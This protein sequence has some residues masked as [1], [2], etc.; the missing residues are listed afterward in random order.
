[1]QAVRVKGTY[2]VVVVG[3]GASGVGIGIAL[4][5]LGIK[6]TI[7]E[8]HDVGASFAR[9][10]QEM[11]FITPSFPSNE[12]GMPDLNAVTRN[13]S[14]AVTL[15][16]EHPTGR[17]YALYLKRVSAHYRL[18]V[19]GGVEVKSVR[20]EGVGFVT[21]MQKGEVRSRFVVWAAGEFQYPRMAGF[22]GAELC[23]HNGSVR[24]WAELEGDEFIVIGGYESGMD[25]AYH[26]CE[27]GRRVKVFD[28]GNACACTDEDPSVSLSPFTR[29][30][31]A[32][33]QKTG[34]VEMI[35]ERVDSVEKTAGGYVVRAGRRSYT[36]AARP[37]SATGFEGSLKL[38]ADLFYWK[39][40]KAELNVY[41]E[42]TR[43]PGLYVA[44][45]LVER[46]GKIFCFIY[47]F[48]QR[49]PVIAHNIAQK[50]GLDASPLERYLRT[51]ETSEPRSRA[52]RKKDACSC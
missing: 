12:F 11:R 32:R 10:P 1:M 22:P 24:S 3:A 35:K 23:V 51:G 34:R 41:D 40:G 4:K 52:P 31:L 37:I 33:A 26:L 49:F 45:P 44:G 47:K 28:G 19:Q 43:T 27:L 21:S 6:F 48:Q 29:D 39:E 14:P 46:N 16:T 50:M 15:K 30:R 25:A 2:D 17:E 42:S 36:T 5:S 8:R 9:W 18:P 13:T 38:I 7:L 20:P